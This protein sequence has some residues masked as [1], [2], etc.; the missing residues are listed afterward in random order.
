MNWDIIKGNWKQMKGQIQSKWGELTDDEIEQAE[1][2]RERLAGLIQE[3]YG[4]AKDEAERQIDAFIA[5]HKSA[6]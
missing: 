3:R 5:E 2:D 6:A 1:G 4:V